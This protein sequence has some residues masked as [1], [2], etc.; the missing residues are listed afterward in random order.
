MARRSED[1]LTDPPPPAADVRLAYGPEPKQFGDL[2]LPADD[3]LIP[4]AIVVH[5]GAW[6]AMY[7][8]IHTGHLSV[9]LGEAGIATWNV[10]YRAVGDPG[11]SWSGA[12]DDVAAA[13]EFVDELI[14]RYP[15]DEERIVLVGHSAGGQL[16]LW[17]A[18]RAQLPVVAVAAVS[19]LRESATRVGPDGAVARFL[20]GMPD[21]VGSHYEAA[22]PRELLPLGVQQVLV[23]GTADEDVP[24]AQSASYVEAAGD[25]AELIT[26]D[27][28]GHFEPIDPQAREWP[29]TLGAIRALISSR[30]G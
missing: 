18:K 29:R 8:L 4:L 1:V 21:E 3:R 12:G 10:E 11:G 7:N 23:H 26:L 15:L 22:S 20:G 13:V 19:D 25:D 14:A 24:Y 6:K 16:A 28:A 27:G 5:G 17:A 2:R 9:A 30:Y